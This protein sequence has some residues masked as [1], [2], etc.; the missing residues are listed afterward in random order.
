MEK[1]TKAAL[2]EMTTTVNETEGK[3]PLLYDEL[4]MQEKVML[5]SIVAHPGWVVVVKLMDAACTDATKQVIKLNPTTPGYDKSLK[6]L[7]Q[8]AQAINRFS[9]QLLTSIDFHTQRGEAQLREDE[10]YAELAATI[11]NLDQMQQ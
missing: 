1:S 4:T 11:A 10:D 8:M 9:A 6:T 5:A 7:H 2:K 3:R